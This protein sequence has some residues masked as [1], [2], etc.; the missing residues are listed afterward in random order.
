MLRILRLQ[1]NKLCDFKENKN[2]VQLKLKFYV[3][4][5]KL[6]KKLFSFQFINILIHFVIK[7]HLFRFQ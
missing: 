6:K 2:F 7:F 4:E 1:S 5:E 3:C